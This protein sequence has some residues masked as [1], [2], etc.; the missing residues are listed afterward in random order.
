MDTGVL[1][2]GPDF[3]GANFAHMFKGSLLHIQR[4]IQRCEV[5]AIAELWEFFLDPSP[6][7]GIDDEL[8]VKV[9]QRITGNANHLRE[10]LD[11]HMYATLFHHA[12]REE[13]RR[14]RGRAPGASTH[15]QERKDGVHR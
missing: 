2:D 12:G 5:D 6:H 4:H 10:L 7:V 13:K 3:E 8:D 1:L 11:A 14:R 9:R 15:Q